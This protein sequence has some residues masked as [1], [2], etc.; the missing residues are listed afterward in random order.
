MLRLRQLKLVLKLVKGILLLGLV[1]CMLYIGIGTM[2]W[3]NAGNKTSFPV[4]EGNSG[5]RLSNS[6]VFPTRKNCTR[7]HNMLVG[8][9]TVDQTVPKDMETVEAYLKLNNLT[10]KIQAGGWWKPSECN[11]IKKTAIIVPFRSRQEQLRVFLRHIHPILQ[12][13]RIHYRIFVAEQGGTE[14]WNKARLLNSAFKEAIKIDNYECLVFNDIDM[15]LENDKLYHDCPSSPFHM[16]TAVD[17]ANYQRP[18][19]FGGVCAMLRRHFED[20][21]GF[22][23]VYWGWGGEDDDLCWRFKFKGYDIV[24]ASSELG[25]YQ[26]MKQYHFRSSGTNADKIKLYKKIKERMAYDGLN[27][28]VYSLKRVKEYPLYTLISVVLE[29]SR[30]EEFPQLL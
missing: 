14:P 29:K 13:Q 5:P 19:C 30:F 11:S 28:L 4:A 10:S 26:M 3:L 12:R 18:S 25:R 22:S 24:K 21:R 8:R 23:N 20:V 2:V 15:L 6:Q 1:F 27:N 16:S 9:L 17:K 7:H